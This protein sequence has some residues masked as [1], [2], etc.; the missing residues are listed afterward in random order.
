MMCSLT[1]CYK[2]EVDENK[3]RE[4]EEQVIGPRLAKQS[5]L[6]RANGILAPNGLKNDG[7]RIRI[8]SADE[9]P[10][11]IK[12]RV[13]LGIRTYLVNSSY[14]HHGRGRGRLCMNGSGACISVERSVGQVNVIRDHDDQQHG[15]CHHAENERLP[16]LKI[17]L[18]QHALSFCQ[19]RRLVSIPRSG[20]FMLCNVLQVCVMVGKGTSVALSGYFCWLKVCCTKTCCSYKNSGSV[21]TG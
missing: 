1:S 21:S 9:I 7:N 10:R 3:G 18:R 17:P 15:K 13:A 2:G 12:R 4:K 16:R 11:F 19:T 5:A 8:R 14:H 6:K 20:I